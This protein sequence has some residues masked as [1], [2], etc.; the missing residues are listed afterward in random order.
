VIGLEIAKEIWDTLHLAHEVVS[1]VKKSKID[2]L[3]AQLNRFVIKDGEGPQEMFDRLMVI[4]GKI[5]GLGGDDLN[6]HHVVKVMLEAFAPR[7]P[8]LVALI[9]EKKRFEEFTPSDVL[10]RILTHELMEMEIQQRKKFGELEA[11]MENLKV[12][13]AFTSSKPPRSRSSKV[14]TVDSSSDSS[15]DEDDEVS[16]GEIGDVA[17]F[18]RKYKKGLKREGYKFV[19]RRIPNKQ[20]RKCYSC[21]STE[22]LIADCPYENKED[23]KDKKK[24]HYKKD[25]KTQHKKNYSGQAHIGHEWDSNN[26]S[27][28]EE[29]TKK[30]QPLLSRSILVHQSS[31]PT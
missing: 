19:E 5:R 31:S 29:E 16:S 20:K 28:S 11:K 2:L 17:L 18:M 7:N 24:K 4:V 30:L 21:G 15:D 14:E 6:D 23:K 25:Y 10:R 13:E 9:R 26:D 27:S 22:H 8:T 12:K 3:M 1:K